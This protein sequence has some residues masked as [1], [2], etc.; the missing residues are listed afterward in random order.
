MKQHSISKNRNINPS[1][2]SWGML[3]QD[4]IWNSGNTKEAMTTNL[5]KVIRFTN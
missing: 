1:L 5:I 4:R 2:M 3:G